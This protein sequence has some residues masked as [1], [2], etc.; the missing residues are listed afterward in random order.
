MRTRQLHRRMVAVWDGMGDVSRAGVG[1]TPGADA[2]ALAA[3]TG[4]AGAVGIAVYVTTVGGVVEVRAVLAV[5]TLRGQ[6]HKAEKLDI[7]KHVVYNSS[8]SGKGREPLGGQGE[9][10]L[11]R[12]GGRGRGKRRKE[13]GVAGSTAK[14]APA[15]P[16]PSLEAAQ[17]NLSSNIQGLRFMQTAREN[18]E[19]KKQEK[20]QL[21]HIEEMQWVVE[22]FEAEVMAESSQEKRPAERRAGPPPC[23]CTDAL[24]GEVVA[25]YPPTFKRDLQGFNGLV[26]QSMKDMLKKHADMMKQSEEVEQASALRKMKQQRVTKS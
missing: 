2:L 9:G 10:K 25:N 1:S 16:P 15:V 6:H 20:E 21:R 19:R 4:G 5:R 23:S 7:G 18:E 13:K 8:R 11:A 12:H 26:E 24:Q 17:H 3:D 14:A 22:G